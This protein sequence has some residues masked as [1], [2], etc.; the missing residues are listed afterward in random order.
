M[1]T[2]TNTE[3][4]T[5]TKYTHKADETHNETRI[6]NA[7]TDA[8]ENHIHGNIGITTATAMMTEFVSFYESYNFW[9]KFW[10]MYIKMF[11]SPIFETDRT[12][13]I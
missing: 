10:E 1:E 5:T 9:V 2:K 7:V 11:A 12:Y 8:E 3:K 4:G 13:Y 6:Y